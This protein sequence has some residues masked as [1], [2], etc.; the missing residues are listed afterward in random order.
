MGSGE[1]EDEGQEEKY[2]NS[3]RKPHLI[4]KAIPD[5]LVAL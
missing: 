1:G 4:G 5:R 3:Q 2:I